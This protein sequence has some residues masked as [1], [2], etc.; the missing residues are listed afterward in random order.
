MLILVFYAIIIVGV[1]M[2]RLL[3]ISLDTLLASFLPIVTWM[4]LGFIINQ[5][6]AN[7]FS[8]TYPLQFVYLLFVSL[9]GIGPNITEKKLKEKNVVSTNL[10]LGTIIVGL[11]TLF[12]VFNIDNYI[13]LMNMD[14]NVYH[15][16]GIYS[17]ISIYFSFLI[18][19]FSQKLYYENRNN[20]A[21]KM[22]IIYHLLSFSSIIFFSIIAKEEMYAITISLVIQFLM[23]CY[24]FVMY[25]RF[26]KFKVCF[27]S[28]FKFTSFEMLDNLSMFLIYGIG[29]GNSFAYG[30]K[31]LNAINFEALTTDSQWDVLTSIE[32]ASRIDLAKD[33]FNYKESLKNAYKLL[34]LLFASTFI[35][36]IVLYWYY[37]PDLGVLSILLL[38][39]FIDMLL[40]PIEA[41]RLNYIQINMNDKKTNLNY[42]ISRVIRILCS[43]IPSAFCTYI[44]QLFS[45]AYSLTFS[46]VKC[47]GVKEFQL[48]QRD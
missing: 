28:N 42:S 18:Q 37:T 27:I 1:I 45:T 48:K 13:S 12:I 33:K 9:F 16:F 35:M 6:I 4:L 2:K 17:V 11:F 23:I 38:V 34:A 8:L 29:F 20:S 7:V 22:N 19:I 47:K 36:N 15:N 3:Q 24:V 39:Q 30:T 25:F 14:I 5:D 21:N 44:G 43:F 46:L 26:S 40:F 32:T 31:Y 41:Y 10:L